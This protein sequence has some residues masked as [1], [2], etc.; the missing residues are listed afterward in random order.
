M[1]VLC[2]FSYF[3][4]LLGLSDSGSD[5]DE[6]GP[7][8]PRNV[9]SQPALRTGGGTGHELHGF[10]QDMENELD[11]TM[12]GVIQ[13]ALG[14][15]TAVAG[16]QTGSGARVKGKS[17]KRGRRGSNA[18]TSDDGASAS[19]YYDD[20]YFDSGSDEEHEGDGS[21]HSVADGASASHKPTGAS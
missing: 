14:A 17:K 21:R 7:V 13:N 9:L 4:L 6:T 1:A 20:I 8:K 5:D 12:K 18:G 3:L 15:A 10:E 19:D 16:D 2:C 11:A